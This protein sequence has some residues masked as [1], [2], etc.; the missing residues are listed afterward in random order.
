MKK[1]AGLSL[2]AIILI[3]SLM[4]YN[5]EASASAD[6][7][8]NKVIDKM[9]REKESGN[10]LYYNLVI[11]YKDDIDSNMLASLY[12][13]LS[14]EDKTK[15]R[16]ELGQ[17]TTDVDIMTEL[18]SLTPSDIDKIKSKIDSIAPISFT[19]TSSLWKEAQD[20]I[21]FMANRGVVQGKSE[22]IF[23]PQDSITR[24]EFAKTI[25]TLLELNNDTTKLDKI[26]NDVDKTG[27]YYD[28]VQIA[29]KHGI[30]EGKND[31]TFAPNDLI[32]RQEM[33]VMIARAMRA[34][35]KAEIVLPLQAKEM[36]NIYEDNNQVA[37]WAEQDIALVVKNKIIQGKDGKLLA[38]KANATRAEAVV[39]LKR[40]FD[41][42]NN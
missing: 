36:L 40:L 24:V 13:L 6:T 10:S 26:F 2:C 4:P 42:L 14:E 21:S 9:I 38:P 3:S 34:M 28:Y 31:T 12:E 17:G 23:A 39:I 7:M 32:T 19:D 11:R 1:I 15:V 35:E 27:W 29:F 41:L 16:N 37:N 25:V 18:K 5:V 20:A 8:I 30:I 33:A 22:G